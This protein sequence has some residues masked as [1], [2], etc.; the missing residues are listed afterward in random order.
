MSFLDHIAFCNA[1]DLA[2][3]V[4]FRV[5]GRHLGWVKRELLAALAEFP[6]T[7]VV[8]DD[9]VTLA[10]DLV[11]PAARSRAMETVARALTD[12]WRDEPY[13]VGARF[14]ETLFTI[15]RSC[16]HLF[17][18]RAHGVH[19]NG[20]TRDGEDLSLWVPRRAA[21]R[22]SYPGQLDNTVAG[23]QPANLGLRANLIKECREEAGIPSALAARAPQVGRLGYRMAV[24]GGMKRDVIFAYDLELPRDFTPRNRDGEVA[25]F[26]L[27]PAA[28]VRDIVENTDDFKF[29]CNLVLIDFFIRHGLLTPDHP[30]FAAIRE[31]LGRDAEP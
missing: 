22:G 6:D 4:P 7:L 23:G 13:A 29:N 27:L 18:F 10:S 11:T 9:G 30:D 15:D 16:V 20:F 12:D 2:N 17:G 25:D 14:G 8:G 5:E 31:R 24:S 21:D 19:L 1:C 26:R 28:D 3:F